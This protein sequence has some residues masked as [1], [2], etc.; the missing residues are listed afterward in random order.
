MLVK[1][2]IQEE[3]EALKKK[4]EKLEYKLEYLEQNSKTTGEFFDIDLPSESYEFALDEAKK[5]GISANKYVS[6]LIMELLDE[7]MPYYKAFEVK[8]DSELSKARTE[9]WEYLKPKCDMQEL[10]ILMARAEI[11]PNEKDQLDDRSEKSYQ[12]TIGLLLELMTSPRAEGGQAP[13]P[14]ETDIIARAT[15]SDKSVYGQGKSKLEERF[16]DAKLIL[17]DTRKKS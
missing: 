4:I 2:D 1:N 7:I 13:F 9:L 12:N 16:R 11:S 6:N 17:A 14:S 5:Q 8:D 15:S 3:N 10:F